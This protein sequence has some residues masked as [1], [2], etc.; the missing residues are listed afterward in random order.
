MKTTLPI[1]ASC[2]CW[3]NTLTSLGLTSVTPLQD[4]QN[5]LR[6]RL[7]ADKI[8]YTPTLR[9]STNTA[10]VSRGSPVA[11]QL[12]SRRAFDRRLGIAIKSGI[13]AKVVP[14]PA[15][16]P[17]TWSK[18]RT[19]AVLA[20]RTIA[21]TQTSDSCPYRKCYRARMPLKS[22]TSKKVKLR[23]A[24]TGAQNLSSLITSC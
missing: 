14:N 2:G 19:A 13:D 11:K 4:D 5:R 18:E 17:K 22:V 8:R 23:R 21:K 12:L 24:I 6:G 15:K 9:E 1:T 10:I 20:G 7:F 16:M 3:Y